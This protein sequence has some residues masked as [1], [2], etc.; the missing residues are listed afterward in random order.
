MNFPNNQ[1]I[2]KSKYIHPQTKPNN[3]I[4]EANII[5][6]FYTWSMSMLS[7]NTYKKK[8]V[9]RNISLAKINHINMNRNRNNR[10]CIEINKW[11]RW[12]QII[13]TVLFCFPLTE[14]DSK[15]VV[16][17]AQP[18]WLYLSCKRHL[19]LLVLFLFVLF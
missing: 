4:D 16:S 9:P 1:K 3:Q 18:V 14:M 12:C 11:G 2:Q 13:N 19:S 5:M 10:S 15:C 8:H 7:R 6:F 17:H